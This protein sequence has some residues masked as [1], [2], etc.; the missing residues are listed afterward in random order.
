[1]AEG[2]MEYAPRWRTPGAS[3][4]PEAGFGW[5]IGSVVQ[6]LRAKARD[7]LEGLPNFGMLMLRALLR[8]AGPNT[9]AILCG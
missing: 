6:P 2:W 4:P 1:M 3:G 7:G 8:R 5:N 9:V